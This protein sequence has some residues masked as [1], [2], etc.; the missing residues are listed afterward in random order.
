MSQPIYVLGHQNP[1]CD[2]IAAALG[3]AELKQRLG[4]EN[5][6]AGRAGEPNPETLFALEHFGVEPPV[7]VEDVHNRV[8]DVMQRQVVSARPDTVFYRAARQL[9]DNGLKILPITEDD[10]R[11]AGV[12]SVADLAE[13]YVDDPTLGEGLTTLANLADALGGRILTGDPTHTIGGKVITAAMHRDT[14]RR[15]IGP[16]DIVLVGDRPEAQDVALEAGVACLVITGGLPVDP[17]VV[18]KAET[19]GTAIISVD[20]DTYSAARRVE[21]SIPVGQVMRRD[22]VAFQEAD[23]LNEAREIA[24]RTKHRNYPV[25]DAAGRLVGLVSRTDLAEVP[26]K[27]VILVDH[28]AQE[29]AVVGIEEAEVIEI[30]DHHRLA[31]IQ[32]AGPIFFRLEPVGSSS[33]IITSMFLENGLKPTPARAGMLLSA[34]LS[35]TLLFKSPTCTPKDRAMAQVLWEVAGVDW[36]QYGLALLKAGSSLRDKTARQIITLDYKVFR[37]S[38]R[39]LGVGQINTMDMEETMARRGELLA[40][41]KQLRGEAGLDAVILMITDPLNELS[42][43]LY[44]T[45]EPRIIEAAFDRAE[46]VGGVRVPGMVSRKKQMIPLLTQ[47]LAAASGAA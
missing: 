38:G 36:Q 41:M 42:E 9:K 10:N 2:S 47:A 5:V 18:F 46:A 32:T 4:Q 27:K 44:D 23:L 1:D 28:N 25:V 13:K 15:Y 30:I 31:D 45:S 20:Q 33:T 17:A 6:I 19:A 39:R 21:M 12:V 37:L 24:A 34:I 7:L 43:V 14:M 3:Y 29:E 11:L 16:G 26:K 40:E 35:D 22:V 8:R